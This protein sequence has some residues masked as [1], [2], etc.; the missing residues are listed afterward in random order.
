MIKALTAAEIYLDYLNNWLTIEKMAE[1]Y[2]ITEDHMQSLIN[3]GKI[4]HEYECLEKTSGYSS[5]FWRDSN[6]EIV[7]EKTGKTIALIPYFNKS[8]Q[9]HKANA[10]LMAAAPELLE[11]LVSAKVNIEE[12]MN[13]E[14]E[15]S[16]DNFMAIINMI[17]RAIISATKE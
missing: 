6:G 4:E 5:S 14:A 17:E 10:R 13:E 16:K 7:Q 12:M 2:G 15:I 8:N 9:E 11:S 1:D 3:R